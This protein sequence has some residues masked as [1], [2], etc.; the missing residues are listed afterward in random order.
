MALILNDIKAGAIAYFDADVLNASQSVAITG[1]P[2]RRIGTSGARNQF[3]CYKVEGE[4]SYWAPLTTA[5][6]KERLRMDPSWITFAYGA[7]QAGEVYLQDGGCTYRD[8]NESFVRSAA[9]EEEFK[10][11]SRPFESDAGIEEVRRTVLARKGQ[12]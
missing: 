7:L 9:E 12:L 2:V 10:Q 5:F 1:S 4:L 6:R 11:G 3:V 8:T